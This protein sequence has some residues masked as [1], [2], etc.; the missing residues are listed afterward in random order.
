MYIIGRQ[1]CRMDLIRLL[2]SRAV[3]R[4][5]GIVQGSGPSIQ[6]TVTTPYPALYIYINTLH[7]HSN[8]WGG[9]KKIPW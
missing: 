3:D 2:G 8:F 1:F 7:T 4:S 9:V 5:L 6:K